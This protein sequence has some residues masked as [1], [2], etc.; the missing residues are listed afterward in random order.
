[1]CLCVCIPLGLEHH[2]QGQKVKGQ[3]VADV[4]NSQHTG[5]GATWRLA[6]KYEDIVMPEQHRHLANKCE[7]TVNLGPRHIVSPRAQLVIIYYAKRGNT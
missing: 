1:M 7:D 6:N 4:S 5:T 2:F 3:L